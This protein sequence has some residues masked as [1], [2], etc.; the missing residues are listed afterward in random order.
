V[1]RSHSSPFN[2]HID[3]AMALAFSR[4]KRAREANYETPPE[5]WDVRPEIF[6]W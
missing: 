3:V 2:A 6:A 5:L 4:A 1:S